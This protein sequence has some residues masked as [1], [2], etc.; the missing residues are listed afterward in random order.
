LT[1]EESGNERA[2][3]S[4][5]IES[6]EALISSEKQEVDPSSEN[7]IENQF[8]DVEQSDADHDLFFYDQ[9]QQLKS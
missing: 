6:V 5:S 3:R 9:I 1:T 4:N 2:N 8:S 7:Y